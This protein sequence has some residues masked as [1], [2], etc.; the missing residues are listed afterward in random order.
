MR[1]RLLLAASLALA[2]CGMFGPVPYE[3]Q[4]LDAAGHP[5]AGA[6]VA[7]D[8]AAAIT[9]AD[10]RFALGDSAGALTV[11]KVRYAPR[12]VSRA[13]DRIVLSPSDR[14]VKVAWDQRWQSPAME[15]LMG[16]LKEQGFEVTSVGSG[17]LPA[18]QDVYV[19]PSPAWF[20]HA[21]YEEYL[22]LAGRGAKL[23]VLGEWGG[24]DGVDLAACNALATKAGITFA[25]AAVRSYS[26]RS[27][28]EWLTF[29]PAKTLLG[30]DL[31]RGVR[32]FTAGALDLQAPAMSLL[33]TEADGIRIQAWSRGA[34]AVAGAGP[35][36]RGSLLALADTSLFTDE[37][38]PDGAPH[39]KSLD[40]PAFAVSLLDW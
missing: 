21:A 23:L 29:H 31:S 13:M 26:D 17:A 3:G 18:D 7:S 40:N 30:T 9:G 19:L 32:L 35:L 5:L 4:V 28:E 36:G 27:P 2:G 25:A 20:S 10:G 16:Y 11:R 15:G 24:Y 1:A 12:T 33:A 39:W 6:V 38:G 37:V 22:R 8:R 34:Q 14:P